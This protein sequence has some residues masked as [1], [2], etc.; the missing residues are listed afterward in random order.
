MVS[1]AVFNERSLPFNLQEDAE[2]GFIGFLKLVSGIENYGFKKIRVENKF[3]GLKITDQDWLEGFF[4][5][6][7]NRD[8]KDKIRLFLANHLIEVDAPLVKDEESEEHPELLNSSYFYK[9]E[10]FFGGLA[11]AGYWNTLALSFNSAPEWDSSFIILKK[12]DKRTVRV[13]HASKYE[14]LDNHQELF[15]HIEK[16][17]RLGINQRNFWQRRQELF[18]KIEFLDKIEDEVARLDAQVFNQFKSIMRGIETGIKPLSELNT[19]GESTTTNNHPHLRS[20]RTFTHQGQRLYFEK[21]IKNLTK[22]H[23]IHYFETETT[24]LIGYVGPHLLT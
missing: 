19:T 24:L 16:E 10:I 12:G 21:H 6:I 20:L 3:S 4:G 2:Q 11:C 9:Q 7:K 22:G 1:F 18:N 13:P 5:K 14:H 8:L 23:R 17:L 15:I